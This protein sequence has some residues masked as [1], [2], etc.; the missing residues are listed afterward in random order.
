MTATAWDLAAK[1]AVKDDTVKITWMPQYC[2]PTEKQNL[3]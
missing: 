1:T 2:I 3:L